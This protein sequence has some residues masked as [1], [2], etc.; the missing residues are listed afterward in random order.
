MRRLLLAMTILL[1]ET[2]WACSQTPSP[3]DDPSQRFLA[4]EIWRLP[5]VPPPEVP[6]ALAVAPA[7]MIP[8]PTGTEFSAEANAPA[9]LSGI[10]S[11]DEA[12]WVEPTPCDNVKLW[13]GS[14][15]LGLDGSEG[16]SETLNFRFGF[17][18]G[19]TTESSILTLGLD[20]NKRTAQ[21][22]ST[23]NRLYFDGRM[24]WLLGQSRWS[25]F[26]HDTVEY[27]EFQPFDVRD[28]S[29]IGMGYRLIK[30]QN[31]TLIG[32]LG[33]GFSHEYGGPE[34]GEYIPEIVFGVQFEHQVSKRQKILASV[35]YA[36]DVG[37]FLR[38]R[39]RTQA[40][41]E[42]LLDADRNL[43]LRMGVLDR[44]NSLPNGA[45][46]ND[47]DYALTLIWKF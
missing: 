7:E 42:L 45:R 47:L 40:A 29:D 18:A 27:D 5:P 2:G 38:Y 44:Y 33:G 25:W 20:Y 6:P 30:N 3:T 34:N 16:N 32:R 19:R 43:S 35:E 31:T 21:T 22:Q 8:T 9:S 14:F 23:T 1:G 28:T 17:H 13:N 36:P 24:E 12:V 26:V 39:I 4:P 10:L 11:G 15:D 46:P 41:W 37:Y